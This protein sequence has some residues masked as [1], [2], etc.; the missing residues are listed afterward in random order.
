MAAR[1]RRRAQ[2][3]AASRRLRHASLHR[4]CANLENEMKNH[5]PGFTPGNSA[6]AAISTDAL[7]PCGRS[8]NKN[9]NECGRDRLIATPDESRVWRRAPMMISRN[10]AALPWP[11]PAANHATNSAKKR[12]RGHR[13]GHYRRLIAPELVNEWSAARSSAI[14]GKAT[15][16]G[17]SH[18]SHFDPNRTLQVRIQR[19]R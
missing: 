18:S 3:R 16:S 7:R 17:C 8:S 2:D 13:T 4:D 5:P 6:Q 11:R 9:A 14:S 12:P 10:G 15:R 19:R 1:Y